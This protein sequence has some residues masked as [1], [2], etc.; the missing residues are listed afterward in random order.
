MRRGAL[1]GRF[2]LE[3]LGQKQGQ[4]GRIAGKHVRHHRL[5]VRRQ[6][7]FGRKRR[8]QVH[9]VGYQ[10]QRIGRLAG[11]PVP[12]EYRRAL[13]GLRGRIRGRNR[14]RAFHEGPH[15]RAQIH[16]D[17]RGLLVDTV[18]DEGRDRAVAA[19][20]VQDQEALEAV[21]DQ[22]LDRLHIDLLH[23]GGGQRDG[24]REPHVVG[25]LTWQQD[26]DHK[27]VGAQ[28]EPLGPFD[29]VEMVG[30]DRQM[31]T[32]LFQ[33]AHGNDHHVAPG[34]EVLHLGPRHVR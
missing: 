28:R 6:G 32:V 5:H 19:V 18:D 31:G 26:R 25:R 34:Q 10:V 1:A 11:A 12:V 22:A 24:A 8:V 17:A 3:S 9:Q 23:Q 14:R 30:A 20:R 21:P 2:V 29:P 33:R 13:P 7:E 4:S 15:D 16:G 27:H